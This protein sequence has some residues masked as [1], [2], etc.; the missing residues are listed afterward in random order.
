M[1]IL[2]VGASG[3]V[4]QETISEL[5]KAGHNLRLF[6]RS[7]DAKKYPA[8]EVVKG[9]VQ[10]K[11]DLEKAIQGCDAVHLTV[12]GTDETK[13][14]ENVVAL[15]STADVKRISYVSG[16]TVTEGNSGF[17]FIGDKY[18]AEQTLKASGIPYMIFRPTWFM[19]SLG[20][21]IQDGKAN[22]MGK[23]PNPLHWISS[24]DFGRQ[25][26]N[27]YSSEEANNKEFYAYGPET[28]TIKEAL[29][30]YIKVKHPEI[31]KVGSAP[32]GLLKVIAFLTRNKQ[33]KDIIPVFEYFEKTRE[34]G[35]ATKTNQ[36]LGQPTIT[37]DDWLAA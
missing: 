18:R 25:L 13:A 35:D 16:A 24:T 2:I 30:K 34:A 3:M 9:D 29:E 37:L 17:P 7:I 31:K 33:L 5:A 26:A 20:M 1:K 23:Q 28:F 12:G 22:V 8:H 19:E 15:A 27:A 36:L 4:A 14:V 21:M 10:N 6:S 11:A 32:F